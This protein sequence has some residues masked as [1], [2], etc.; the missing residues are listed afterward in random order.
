MRAKVGLWSM[1]EK[2]RQSPG[3]WKPRDGTAVD[4]GHMAR[5]GVVVRSHAAVGV[6]VALKGTRGLAIG[7]LWIQRTSRVP[8]DLLVFLVH[9]P[10][11]GSD[12]CCNRDDV[13]KSDLGCP[14]K[15]AHGL[16]VRGVTCAALKGVRGLTMHKPEV[17]CTYKVPVSLLGGVPVHRP[18]VGGVARHGQDSEVYG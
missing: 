15:G 4:E 6:G 1:R 14:V 5:G 17:Q 7:K 16:A 18:G 10:R 12:A 9:E 8:V 2:A 13:E 3:S 11:G